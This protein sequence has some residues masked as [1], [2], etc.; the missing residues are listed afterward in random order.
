[1]PAR[2]A[3]PSAYRVAYR[4]ALSEL[5]RDALES[6]LSTELR[7]AARTIDS[8]KERV[9]PTVL[10]RVR[11][12]SESQGAPPGRVATWCAVRRPSPSPSLRP[13]PDSCCTSS[14]SHADVR[15]RAR[16]QRALRVHRADPARRAPYAGRVL[17][18]HAQ[19]ARAPRRL[20]Q[21]RVGATP[22]R[23]STA[24]C[25]WQNAAWSVVPA[26]HVLWPRAPR[27]CARPLPSPPP[28]ASA[29]G[30]AKKMKEQKKRQR[31]GLARTLC[32]FCMRPDFDAL[33]ATTA[34]A[35]VSNGGDAG[36]NTATSPICASF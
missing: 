1:M 21:I 12:H 9:I 17:R 27:A 32:R 7:E 11:Q 5:E 13:R 3:W 33:P 2:R 30:V 34:A 20:H 29:C 15:R 6:R 19:Q 22:V 23:H 28:P 24:M 25:Q 8:L 36:A 14:L 4:A 16:L 31:A 26:P 18:R 10:Q 35:A